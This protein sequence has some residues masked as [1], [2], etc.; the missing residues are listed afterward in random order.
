MLFPVVTTCMGPPPPKTPYVVLPFVLPKGSDLRVCAFLLNMMILA[1]LRPH[2]EKAMAAGRSTFIKRC[3]LQ[4]LMLL[5]FF[6]RATAN[7]GHLYV[8][9]KLLPSILI[10]Y[11]P[12]VLHR[13]H[14]RLTFYEENDNYGSFSWK[15]DK[16]DDSCFHRF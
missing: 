16:C 4:A 13:S 12:L 11:I 6:T 14:F 10:T 15:V 1:I 8:K 9:F 2:A 7:E 3:A 5:T